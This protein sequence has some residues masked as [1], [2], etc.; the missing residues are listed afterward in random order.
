MLEYTEYLIRNSEWNSGVVHSLHRDAAQD[1]DE[2]LDVPED[3]A[4]TLRRFFTTPGAYATTSLQV[5]I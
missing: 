4:S 1:L 2:E 5:R 3:I